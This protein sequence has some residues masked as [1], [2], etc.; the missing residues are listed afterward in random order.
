MYGAN[1]YSLTPQRELP[2]RELTKKQE[3]ENERYRKKYEAAAAKA[4]RALAAA[5]K[6]FGGTVEYEG[7]EFQYPHEPGYDF[8]KF[9]DAD[10]T[11][12]RYV[13]PGGYWENTSESTRRLLAEVVKRGVPV[14]YAF[15][16][17]SAY[18]LP[19]SED[20]WK[21]DCPPLPDFVREAMKK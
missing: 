8:A 2:W 11:V 21:R 5:A 19:I 10:W 17:C 18:T 14:A 7:P 13:E 6:K 12:Y 16:G 20:T 4:E 9:D 3:R 1:G 15:T